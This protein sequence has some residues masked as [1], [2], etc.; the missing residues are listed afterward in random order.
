MYYQ[1][2][3]FYTIILK[4][5]MMSS[6]LSLF[7]NANFHKI[8]ILKSKKTQNKVLK[9]VSLKK[10]NKYNLKLCLQRSLLKVFCK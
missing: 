10:H 4:W 3:K 5:I 6:L 1:K 2:K 7:I 8:I 9:V